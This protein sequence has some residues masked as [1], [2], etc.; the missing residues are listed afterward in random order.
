MSSPASHVLAHHVLVTSD[1]RVPIEYLTQGPPTST[2]AMI[3]TRP[4]Q[5]HCTVAF[6]VFPSGY[7]YSVMTT[8]HSGPHALRGGGADYASMVVSLMAT[9]NRYRFTPDFLRCVLHG[10]VLVPHRMP[11]Q[12]PMPP[13]QPV[14]RPA[15]QA[16]STA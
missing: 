14:N 5:G 6:S 15:E 1:S 12:P 9:F 10:L 3:F 4:S 11:P 7:Y 8:T 16:A 13:A 2:G